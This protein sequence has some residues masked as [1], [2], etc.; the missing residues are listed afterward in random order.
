MI[1]E[2]SEYPEVEV[3]KGIGANNNIEAFDNIFTQHGYCKRLKS[4]NEPLSNSNDS[5]LLQKY[6]KWACIDHQPAEKA[7]DPRSQWFSRGVYE[8]LQ[9]G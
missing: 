7:E 9:K 8:D 4:D 5:H 1:D 2:L 6:L 3:V